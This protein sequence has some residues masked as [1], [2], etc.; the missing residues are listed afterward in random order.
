[1]AFFD[2]KVLDGVICD[3]FSISLL[4]LHLFLEKILIDGCEMNQSTLQ[5]QF[6]FFFSVEN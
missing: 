6:S 3:Q 1:M 4:R 5:N 2:D